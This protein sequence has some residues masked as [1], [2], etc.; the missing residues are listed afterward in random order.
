M[1]DRTFT[2]NRRHLL[3]GA[4]VLGAAVAT[5]LIIAGVAEAYSWP[6]T[7]Q[8][9]MSGGDVSELQIRV[10]GWASDGPAQARIAVDGS[11]GPATAG[12]V[13]RVP[14]PRRRPPRAPRRPQTP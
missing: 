1:S 4:V 3:R 13:R 9:G 10:G 11:F 8:Q 6:R 7:L 14:G 12:P 2:M 5:P